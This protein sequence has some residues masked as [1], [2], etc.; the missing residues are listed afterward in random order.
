MEEAL[1]VDEGR[2]LLVRGTPMFQVPKDPSGRRR[3]PPPLTS[4]LVSPRMGTKGNGGTGEQGVSSFCL[5]S[6]HPSSISVFSP[7]VAPQRVSQWTLGGRTLSGPL[8]HTSRL[9]VLGSRC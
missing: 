1:L 4:F 6:L 9:S 8:E 2:P 7:L 3:R 5:G